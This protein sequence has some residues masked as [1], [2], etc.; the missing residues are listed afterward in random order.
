LN[1]DKPLNPAAFNQKASV[2]PAIPALEISTLR[3]LNTWES[4]Q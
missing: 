2:G 4:Q 1:Q 3:V